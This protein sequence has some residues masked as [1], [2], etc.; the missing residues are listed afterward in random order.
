MGLKLTALESEVERVNVNSNPANL[1]ND[2][3]KAQ[4][5]KMES[6]MKTTSVSPGDMLE[7][8]KDLQINMTDLKDWKAKASKRLTLVEQLQSK[9]GKMIPKTVEQII[10]QNEDG[11]FR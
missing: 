2:Q 1:H 9:Q 6:K 5:L 4:L 8:L 11:T 7:G 3:L 10:K